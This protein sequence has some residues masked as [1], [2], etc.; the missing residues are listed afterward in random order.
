MRVVSV[1]RLL[2]KSDCWRELAERSVLRY[3]QIEEDSGIAF[4]REVGFLSLIDDQY[5]DTDKLGQALERLS[6]SGYKY[7]DV[8]DNTRYR[9][10][11]V[12]STFQIN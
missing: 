7:E 9:V 11:G 4:Y 8:K 6:S 5:K 1:G 2:D 12:D 3:R 10:L